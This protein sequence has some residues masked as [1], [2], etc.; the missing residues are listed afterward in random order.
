[1][2]VTSEPGYS[3]NGFILSFQGNNKSLYDIK[4]AGNDFES[5]LPKIREANGFQSGSK[6]Y[7]ENII[8]RTPKNTTIKTRMVLFAE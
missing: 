2:L 4:I 1:M 3:I 6:I 7:F 5:A 8:I